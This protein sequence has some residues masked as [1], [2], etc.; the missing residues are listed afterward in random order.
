[1]ME[2]SGQ[3]PSR[4]REPLVNNVWELLP[5]SVSCQGQFT[6]FCCLFEL[7]LRWVRY[8]VEQIYES[9]M[10]S[11]ID[12]FSSALFSAYFTKLIHWY[13]YLVTW[14]YLLN[15]LCLIDCYGFSPT[16]INRSW[17]NWKSQECLA[18]AQYRD[19][20]V[21]HSVSNR[22]EA[23]FWGLLNKNLRNCPGKKLNP[24]KLVALC[25]FWHC[26]EGCENR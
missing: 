22:S 14:K 13:T 8:V 9:F 19:L 23:C 4:S 21:Q 18:R 3:A 15:T 25:R 26:S 1:M 17:K 5:L 24:F 2:S 12:L 10:H 20:F 16:N 11:R 7:L 6:H